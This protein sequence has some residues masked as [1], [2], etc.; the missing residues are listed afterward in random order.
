MRY[1]VTGNISLS[2]SSHPA[3]LDGFID[4]FRREV[5]EQEK[6][7]SAGQE[8]LPSEHDAQKLEPEQAEPAQSEQSETAQSE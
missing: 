5:L 3:V 4:M 8:K 6:E 2:V 7:L 1:D